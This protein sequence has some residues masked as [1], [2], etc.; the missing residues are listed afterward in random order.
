M[1][2][3]AKKGGSPSA[4]TILSAA[5]GLQN[6]WQLHYSEEGGRDHNVAEPFI[7]NIGSTDPGN[8]IKVAAYQ[9]GRLTVFNS[10]TKS[11]KTYAA[12]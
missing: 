9:D 4:W 11:E 2:N 3:A 7:A 12:Q 5:P 10:R 8:Y 6:L 1:D